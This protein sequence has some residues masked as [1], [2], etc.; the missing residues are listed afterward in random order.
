M[1]GLGPSFGRGAMTNH[2]IDYRNADV[3]LVLGSNTCENHPVSTT[4]ID[5]AMEKGGKLIVV[6]P[7][8]TR[9]ASKANIY[10]PL[11]P[12]TDIAF[13]GGLINYVLQN[14]LY[15]EE[16]LM[17]Y[18]NVSFLV[19]P[20]YSF[21][22]GIFSGYDKEK[23]KYDM[24]TWGYQMSPP[25]P[26]GKTTPLQ[27]KTLK[28]PNCVYQILKK[29]YARYTPDMVSKVC[30]MP[31]E[32][33]LEIA[34][35][36]A[37]TG[38]PGKAGTVLYAMGITQHSNG[39]QNVR[40]ISE[41]QILLGNMGIAGGG[42]NA[43]RGEANVQGSTDYAL[44]FHLV[45]GYMASPDKVLHP[46][47]SDYLTKETPKSGY[48]V[49][50]PKFFV[51]LLKAW[52]GE[53]AT[54]ENNFCYDYLPKKSANYSWIA[55]FEAMY[56]GKIKGLSCWGENPAV[57]GPNSN[58]EVKALGNLDWLVV[59]DLFET[60][61]ASFWKRPGVNPAEIKTEVFLLPAC[62]SY[63][64]E[65]SITNSGRWAQWRWKACP[66][67]GESKSDLEMM[68]ELFE[69]IRAL[70]KKDAKAVFPEPIVKLN[71]DYG[72]GEPNQDK[73]VKEINGYT[74]ADGKPV[75]NFT[76]LA[77][78]GST[79]CGNWIYSGIYPEDGKNL[80]KRRIREKEG[81]GLNSEWAFAWPVNRR[82]IY[83]RCSANPAGQPY[84]KDKWLVRWN[85]TEK[86]WETRDVPD[87]GWKDAKTGEMIPPEKSAA[88][89]YIMQPEGKA[90]LF[91]PVGMADGPMAEHY[92]PYESPVKNLLSGT[93]NDPAV[94]IWAADL[95]KLA[96]V[97]S[98]EYPIIATTYRVVE[99]YQTG[100]LTR[101]LPW[102]AELMPN[103]FVE[104]SVELAQAKGIKNGDK[105]K[106]VSIRGEVEA[107][108]CV[109]P[110]LKAYQL[111][112]KTV[113][114]VG[115]P[116][117]W[118]WATAAPGDV[119]N[120]ITPHIGDANTMIPEYKAFLVDIKKEVA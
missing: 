78:D 104:M 50:K 103:L 114:V 5:E 85:D 93:Q 3:I 112:G 94:K 75:A 67:V 55:L 37:T 40:A 116:W 16:Y 21:K 52:W 10:A 36:Y 14:K 13:L 63:E 41:L 106:V 80:L 2:W 19:K 57:S 43:Q 28:D 4:W 18:S 74:I 32:S 66:A 17:N 15:H 82:I 88:N 100:T 45:P 27:D 95:D 60:E 53:N 12:G 76:K 64:K 107:I 108:A 39:S 101:N 91:T 8:F 31:K 77:D 65:G 62:G 81:I 115:L 7:R 35:V 6:D 54:K 48:W 61:T 110:R 89:P 69:E 56:A 49:N 44:L 68:N 109:T 23:R 34:K 70:Y 118:G 99:H 102:L 20:E 72:K 38:K 26:D 105:V 86:K 42:V 46:I 84:N 51:S 9:T 83:N 59:S 120:K 119:T 96:P 113:E 98:P 30:G 97:A 29:H 24:A 90:R 47:L 92:E 117:H 1:A 111:N 71:W 58:L 11:R 33:F 25:G 87:F 79:M 73:I 22:D